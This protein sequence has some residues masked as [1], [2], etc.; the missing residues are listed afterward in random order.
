MPWRLEGLPVPLP[1]R[2]GERLRVGKPD[3][4]TISSLFTPGCGTTSSKTYTS[5]PSPP[6]NSAQCA[7][8]SGLR[9]SSE[10]TMVPSLSIQRKEGGQ[11]GCTKVVLSLG[12]SSSRCRGILRGRLPND[13]PVGRVG[14]AG[15]GRAA[16]HSQ[17]TPEQDDIVLARIEPLSGRRRR[18]R[19]RSPAAALAN[20]G[21]AKLNTGPVSADGTWG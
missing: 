14:T 5:G 16:S 10:T 3:V 2:L 1:P 7:H 11:D 13:R 6:Q 12:L 4:Q 19:H 20:N 8:R 21:Q 9:A 15:G 18:A 17:R